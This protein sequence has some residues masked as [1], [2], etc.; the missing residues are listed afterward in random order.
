MILFFKF[1]YKLSN[2]I[3]FFILQLIVK[4]TLLIAVDVNNCLSTFLLLEKQQNYK[5]SIVLP[6][7]K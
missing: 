3:L 7:Q 6:A 1:E 5:Y 4:I 2:F